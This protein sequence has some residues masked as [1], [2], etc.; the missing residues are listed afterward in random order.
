MSERA[1]INER[2]PIVI[3]NWYLGRFHNPAVKVT[4]GTGEIT[5]YPERCALAEGRRN[6]TFLA[7]LGAMNAQIDSTL[8]RYEG[9]AYDVLRKT[10]PHVK[11]SS[12]YGIARY[13]LDEGVFA[14]T[15]AGTPLGLAPQEALVVENAS[16][17]Y[18]ER[19]IADNCELS[20]HTVR[21]YLATI[22]T[23]SDWHGRGR[24]ALAAMVSGEIGSYLPETPAAEL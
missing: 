20:Q 19:T 5:F 12:R 1:I 6:V 23:K 11:P 13:F 24:I 15:K 16:F 9:Y 7:S 14:V 10:M 8:Y 4:V 22:A 21:S 3:H 2:P 17:G 18:R